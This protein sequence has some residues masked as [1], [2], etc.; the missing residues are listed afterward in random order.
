MSARP[1]ADASRDVPQLILYSRCC[2]CTW[3][4]RNR[5][6]RSK[7][8]LYFSYLPAESTTLLKP[9]LLLGFALTLGFTA[10]ADEIAMP[11]QSVQAAAPASL[12]GKGQT[13]AEVVRR[14]G[15]P[16]QKHAAAG[17]DAPKHP[18]ITRWDYA[19]FSVF[20]EHTHVVDAVV[21]GDPPPVYHADQLR[22]T[23]SR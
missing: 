18:P 6:K 21:P 4:A 9:A 12:P 14:F 16:Q 8:V 22:Q 1:Q 10:R 7:R 3:L 17:G 5:C 23:S 20:F 11:V 15:E 13:M 19:G 2:G